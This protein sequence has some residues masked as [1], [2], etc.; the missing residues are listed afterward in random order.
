VHSNPPLLLIAGAAGATGSTVA[1]AIATMKEAPE[2]VLPWLTTGHWF[3]DLDSL[4]G[5]RLAGWDVAPRTLEQAIEYHGVLPPEKY[6]P[7]LEQ[8]GTFPIRHA[9]GNDLPL[10]EQVDHLIR[11]IRD[12]TSLF[13]D[14]HPVLVNLLPAT[15]IMDLRE[16]EALDEIYSQAD[17]R[18]FPDLAYVLAALSTGTPFVNFTSNY[19]ELPLLAREALRAGVPLC[20][21]DGK[22]G[23][24]YLKVVLAS[25]LKARGLLVDGWYSLNILGN[26]DGRNLADPDKAS[27]K[28]SNKT[29]LLED[30]LGYRVGRQY[31]APSHKV[32]IDYYPPR[33]DCKEAWDVIDFNGLF[34]LP[35]SLRLNLQARDS[36][37]AAPMIIDLTWWMVAV[38]LAKRPGLV[39]ELGFY[40]KKPTGAHTPV[41]FQDQLAALQQLENDCREI[42]R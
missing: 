10:R 42:I 5:M 25:A 34:G 41:T 8:L 23:Q 14:T 24:T 35:M 20:G 17:A 30:I 2:K 31:G 11:D 3:K 15:W 4:K 21:R 38:H 26:E 29:E 22:T 19:L 7:R 27:G 36:V 16:F 28:I 12:F 39:P 40:F 6:L 32:V 1:A 37:L 13:P 33:G 18:N 9:P